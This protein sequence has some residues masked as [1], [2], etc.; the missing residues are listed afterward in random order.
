MRNV[1]G[2]AVGNHHDVHV[3]G[4]AELLC[5]ASNLGSAS[6]DLFRTVFERIV[7]DITQVGDL[8]VIREEPEGRN[9]GDL[10]DFT[11]P[12]WSISIN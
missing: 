10:G 8:E 2:V 5:L 7:G 11:T 9:V 12:G 6:N 3:W 1:E 4:G